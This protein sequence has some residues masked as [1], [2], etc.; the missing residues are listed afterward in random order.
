MKLIA[1][2]LEVEARSGEGSERQTVVEDA[3]VDEIPNLRRGEEAGAAQDLEILRRTLTDVLDLAADDELRVHEERRVDVHLSHDPGVG[4]PVAGL[5]HRF[6]LGALDHEP[7]EVRGV[8]ELR[9]AAGELPLP[10]AEAGH[11]LVPAAL[12]LESHD[13]VATRLE[14]ALPDHAEA[15]DEPHLAVQLADHNGPRVLD[16]HRL[17]VEVLHLAVDDLLDHD[18]DAG[19]TLGL[20]ERSEGGRGRLPADERSREVLFLEQSELTAPRFVDTHPYTS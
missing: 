17:I 19:E 5:F 4:H 12:A 11:E 18:T 6:R 10:L 7:L 15:L 16:E 2:P 20:H 9:E 14:D 8:A 3:G 1:D 13:V